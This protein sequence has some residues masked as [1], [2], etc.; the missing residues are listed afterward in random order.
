MLLK[1]LNFAYT[2]KR[3][4]KRQ[5]VLL[6]LLS[7]LTCL[8]VLFLAHPVQSSAPQSISQVAPTN[9]AT[10]ANQAASLEQ[11]GRILYETGRYEEAADVLEQAI[12][13]YQQQSNPL[14][15]AVALSNLALIHRQ[16]GNWTQAN[17]TITSSLSLLATVPQ[18][19]EDVTLAMA[20][21][22]D[23]QG[24]IQMAQSATE[25]ALNSW[26]QAAERYEQI[27]ATERLTRNQINQSRALQ[28]LGFYGKAVD[29]L[30]T[31]AQRLDAQP[32]SLMKA[33]NLRSLGE[34][35]RAVGDFEDAKA[36]LENS[37]AIAQTLQPL[38]PN[39]ASSEA[40][41]MVAR[42]QLSLGNLAR[43]QQ[44]HETA[45]SW[46]Q[47]ASASPDIETRLQTNINLLSLRTELEQ[48]AQ[49][50]P[51]ISQV[52]QQLDEQPIS[53]TSIYMR[54]N[55]ADTLSKLSETNAREN[56]AALFAIAAQQS[57]QIGDRR[58]QSYAIG[59]LGKL[60]EETNQLS[61]AK[62]LTEQA[63][64]LSTSV[65]AAEVTYLW[66]W[67]LG[68][69]LKARAE[70][71]NAAAA[72]RVEDRDSA[73]QAYNQAVDT[74]RSLRLDIASI[75]SDSSDQQF[76][77]SETVEP[78]YREQIELLLHPVAGEPTQQDLITAR[79][80]LE[81]L[82]TVELQNFFRE[83]CLDVPM[84]IDRIVEQTRTLS[85][86]EGTNAAVI[87][88]IILDETL[89]VLLKLPSDRALRHY[90]VAVS[91]ANV[92]ETLLNLRSEIT[93][94]ESIATIE[95]LSAQVYDWLIRPAKPDL[96]REQINTLVFVLDGFLKNIP[97]AALY[98]GERYL[99]QDYGI[100]LTPG[101]E[102]LSPKPIERQRMRLL[103]AGVSD[104][105][106]G[107]SPLEAVEVEKEG[108]EAE[109]PN[110]TVLLNQSFTAETLENQIERKTYQVV[111]L[112]THG[113]FSSDRNGTF[114]QSSD[115]KMTMDEINRILSTKQSQ[116]DPIELLT[117]S[118][119][120][121]AKGDKRAAL[122]LAG[123][124]VRAGARS[125]LAS[126]WSTDDQSNAF[127][128][129]EF[130]RQ[131]MQNPSFSKSQALRQAQLKLVEHPNYH[132]PSYWAPYVLLG[133]W[134]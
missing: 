47:Q 60:Y 63:L 44:Q 6:A 133:N 86:S 120:E 24:Q 21:A 83:A 38:Q 15:T 94:P 122:G 45:L 16:L 116:T 112:A 4:L 19:S 78:A 104:T 102:L 62:A 79:E 61:E 1:S 95:Q 49:I 134:L 43:S 76:S 55:L 110:T 119:C 17:S 126:L 92:E 97:M 5:K 23:I 125:T 64:Q 33:E 66:H 105:V 113:E 123:I 54:I 114:I 58:T 36:K 27:N 28:T 81:S 25:Q 89:E 90:S 71:A 13:T 29:L 88:P 124:A 87:Y 128:M 18:R 46:Y 73:I 32:N 20:Q 59:L 7:V 3:R 42:S 41:M 77:F 50:Q 12:A 131:L 103:F 48:T 57:Q 118:A 99:I 109:I 35:L 10:S 85:N 96:E 121:T 69:I 39:A 31:L 108:I 65:N 53:K 115:R 130:Y 93:Q 56:A 22:L 30:R 2:A 52:Q 106:E 129:V 111:H 70:N 26:Q 37:L 98:S 80:A 14:H 8:C 132:H 68:R 51:L 67:Q 127:V 40:L 82:Q 74:L 84:A 9:Q 117:L 11:Q 75:G 101:L 91:Q 34:G 100:A 107:F 72:Q